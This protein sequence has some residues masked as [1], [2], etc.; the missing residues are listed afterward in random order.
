MA[1]VC[2]CTI[3]VAGCSGHDHS[4]R[5]KNLTLGTTPPALERS[6]L[7][8]GKSDKTTPI[9]SSPFVVDSTIARGASDSGGQCSPLGAIYRSQPV[10]VPPP[11]PNA[12]EQSYSGGGCSFYDEYRT[13]P[14]IGRYE[15]VW[16]AETTPRSVSGR[17]VVV[18]VSRDGVV[19]TTLAT[20]WTAK[21]PHSAVAYLTMSGNLRVRV[22][23]G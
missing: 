1:A 18:D 9:N 11:E 13:F 20:E 19:W 21:K 6:L 15:F 22:R 12:A 8:P 23:V 3:V 7:R 17:P 10:A 16:D 5:T 2:L 4:A 14:D